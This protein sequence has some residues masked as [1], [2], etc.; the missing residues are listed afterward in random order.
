MASYEEK[1]EDLCINRR[2]RCKGAHDLW[3]G[4]RPSSASIQTASMSTVLV[5]VPTAMQNSPLLPER[6]P[7]P[8]PVSGT[9]CIYP[10]RDGQ[11]E[12]AWMVWI[13]TG[14][15]DPPKS[16]TF[17]STDWT[18]RSLTLFMCPTLVTANVKSAY[19]LGRYLKPS[20]YDVLTSVTV[21]VVAVMVFMSEQFLNGTSAQCGY[22]VP[23]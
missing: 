21:T 12:W 5:T 1:E 7:K 17:P 9:L 16:V 20:I 6:W 15:V 18:R 2:V 14:M 23:W 13:N 11:A 3:A 19:V 22:T 10:R 4:D 8:S